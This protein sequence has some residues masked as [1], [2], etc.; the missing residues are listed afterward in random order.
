[1]GLPVRSWPTSSSLSSRNDSLRWVGRR[2]GSG[3]LL[4]ATREPATGLDGRD[5]DPRRWRMCVPGY[6]PNRG[7]SEVASGR[8]TTHEA[9]VSVVRSM[10]VWL[11]DPHG[12]SSWTRTG[13][14]AFTG[15]ASLPVAGA[16]EKK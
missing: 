10:N 2:R 13:S 3:V 7:L 1:M 15:M 16:P 8:L 5:E 6:F 14:P 11:A 4:R 9:G 12:I